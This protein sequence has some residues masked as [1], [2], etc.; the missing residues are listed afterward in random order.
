MTV[1]PFAHDGIL[2]LY[3]V[4]ELLCTSGFAAAGR[5]IRI[6]RARTAPRGTRARALL[7]SVSA[8]CSAARPLAQARRALRYA[9]RLSVCLLHRKGG[10]SRESSACA[11]RCS[12]RTLTRPRRNPAPHSAPPGRGGAGKPPASARCRLTADRYAAL[13]ALAARETA[14][15]CARSACACGALSAQ[16]RAL[17]YPHFARCGS[18]RRALPVAS[19]RT[20]PRCASRVAR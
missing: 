2:S 20:P 16:R 15:G 7:P 9:D 5:G 19:G 6:D 3:Q 14:R 4:E 12:A 8:D 13:R 11:P 17:F 18:L 10:R 1:F